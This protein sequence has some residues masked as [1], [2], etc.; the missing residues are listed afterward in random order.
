[1][2]LGVWAKSG[3]IPA[4]VEK[5]QDPSQISD[6]DIFQGNFP[7]YSGD[8]ELQFSTQMVGHPGTV[9]F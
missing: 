7:E 4:L 9:L 6:R 8:L 2:W 3:H 5:I 1:M